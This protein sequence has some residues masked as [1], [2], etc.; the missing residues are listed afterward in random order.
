MHG[1]SREIA[2]DRYR[3][4]V[5]QAV[6]PKEA[7]QRQGTEVKVMPTFEEARRIILE[8]ATPLDAERVDLLARCP[9]CWPKMLSHPGTCPR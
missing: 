9:R 2:A 3:Q 8:Y 6:I 7:R 1:R 5:R 4:P